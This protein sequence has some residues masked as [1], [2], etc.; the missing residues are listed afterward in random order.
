[1]HISEYYTGEEPVF[2]F[3]FF[4]PANDKAHAS[5]LKT[6]S[7]LHALQP[8]FVSVT[9]GAGGSTRDR[10]LELVSWIKNTVGLEAMAHLTCVGSSRDELRT[11]L[12]RLENAG[13]E[14]LIALR[15]DP[16]AGDSEF[17]PAADG[18]SYASELIA[19]I[20][21]ENRPFCLAAAAYPEVHPE[22]ESPE[23]DLERLAHKVQQGAEVLITQLF[24]DNDSFFAFRDRAVKAG[25][26]VPI[27]PGIMPVTGGLERMARF[28][29][30]IP[31]RLRRQVELAGDD[32]GS[33][34]DAGEAWA[35][36]QCAALLA[37]GVPG[38]HFY[39][40]NRSRA[41]RNVLEKIRPHSP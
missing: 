18:L 24:F 21:D 39:T 16:P 37:E 25:I 19:M 40:L 9:Y 36:E 7:E 5:L 17:K 22:A 35:T 20:R 33:I 29:A 30:A 38:L 31:A 3:E 1:M 14:N 23:A 12:D 8:H 6:I 15:G 2:S 41:T 13:I 4:P 32:T 34:A 28:G 11:M 27:V 26:A 10:T